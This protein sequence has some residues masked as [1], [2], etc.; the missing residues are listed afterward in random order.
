MQ[1]EYANHLEYISSVD[2]L[3]ENMRIVLEFNAGPWGDGFRIFKIEKLE[4][5]DIQCECPTCNCSKIRFLCIN[6][7]DAPNDRKRIEVI[8]YKYRVKELLYQ[9][10]EVDIYKVPSDWTILRLEGTRREVTGREHITDYFI[11]EES[12]KDNIEYRNMFTWKKVPH[13]SKCYA[14]IKGVRGEPDE[15][16]YGD[17]Q[18]NVSYSD[19]CA[20]N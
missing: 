5:S 11:Q 13:L 15:E 18:I 17:D 3:E 10:K 14:G 7:F 2:M 8:E 19:T 16:I 12:G 20:S 9:G 6:P 4:R 1:R